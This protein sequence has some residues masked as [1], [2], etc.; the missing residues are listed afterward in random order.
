MIHACLIY[1]FWWT[2]GTG[3][4]VGLKDELSLWR[5]DGRAQSGSISLDGETVDELN[6]YGVTITDERLPVVDPRTSNCLKYIVDVAFP[7]EWEWSC[8]V[9]RETLMELSSL[10]GGHHVDAEYIRT[11]NTPLEGTISTERIQRLQLSGITILS[12]RDYY[13]EVHLRSFVISWSTSI[14]SPRGRLAIFEDTVESLCLCVAH[15]IL[16]TL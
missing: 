5:A 11:I 14:A 4:R 12:H 6:S 3:S 9:T 8:D 10:T 13:I 7:N 16:C 15:V 1:D 2:V